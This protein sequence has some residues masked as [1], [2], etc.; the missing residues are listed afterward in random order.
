M[1]VGN[2]SN[3]LSKYLWRGKHKTS[4]FVIGIFIPILDFTYFS[5]NIA[6]R[7]AKILKDLVAIQRIIEVNFNFTIYRANL[8]RAKTST[9]IYQSI[10]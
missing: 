10:S 2:T 9:L 8:L 7:N 6:T 5:D 4:W 3:F 1:N